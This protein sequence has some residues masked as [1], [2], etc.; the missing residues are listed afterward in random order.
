MSTKT[1]LQVVNQ[2]LKNL[3][4]ATVADFSSTYASLILEFVN[5]SKE[6]VEDAHEWSALSVNLTFTTISAQ[7]TY[8]LT[9]AGTTPV[10]TT[11]ASDSRFANERSR[12]RYDHLNRPMVF[13]VTSATQPIRLR[14]YART[15]Q[16]IAGIM[17]LQNNTVVKPYAYSFYRN[18]GKESVTLLNQPGGAYSMRVGLYVPQN[19]LAAVGDVLLVPW[20]PVV[21]SATAIAFQERGEELGENGA[22]WL[23]KAS[24]DLQVAIGQDSTEI[25][26]TYYPD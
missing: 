3:R 20:R 12:V 13:D 21:T 4:K 26:N 25:Q 17:G 8:D 1:A 5:Q 22:L 19:E 9:V 24:R 2:V 14:E 11:D 6:V 18:K 15:E 10:I 7:Q 16:E 23:S